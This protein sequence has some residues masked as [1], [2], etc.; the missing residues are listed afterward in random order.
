MDYSPPG[1]GQ[2]TRGGNLSFLQGIF[3]TQ[4]LNQGLLHCRQ[5]LYQLSYQEALELFSSF[6]PIYLSVYLSFYHL[7]VHFLG[8]I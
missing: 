6:P 8:K 4:R 7:S 2:N 3:P 1:E 5:I